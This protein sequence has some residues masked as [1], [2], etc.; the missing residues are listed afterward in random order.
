MAIQ[1]VS[2]K[3][4]KDNVLH[5][6]SPNVKRANIYKDNSKTALNNFAA[7]L[8]NFWSVAP[9]P[10]I[11]NAVLGVDASGNIIVYETP[12]QLGV[13]VTGHGHTIAQIV[14]VSD[15]EYLFSPIGSD[16]LNAWTQH[17]G[18]SGTVAVDGMAEAVEDASIT[19][20]A[21]AISYIKTSLNPSS[22]RPGYMW[23]CS[24]SIAAPYYYIVKGVALQ[25]WINAK[26]DLNNAIEAS[27][28]SDAVFPSNLD[29]TG[30]MRFAGTV[31]PAATSGAATEVGSIFPAITTNPDTKTGMYYITVADGYIKATGMNW[32][33]GDTQP[34]SIFLKK[35][36]WII[37]V[38]YEDLATDKY[39]FAYINN[40]YI[41]AATDAL[42]LVQLSAQHS[43]AT[44]VKR[45]GLASADFAANQVVTEKMLANMGLDIYQS[46]E[47][48]WVR[49]D[50][51]TGGFSVPTIPT[52]PCE[53]PES[54]TLVVV[55][56]TNPTQKYV[57]TSTGVTQ[58]VFNDLE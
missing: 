36:A 6:L 57:C 12:A 54:G 38:K 51:A 49:N 20:V 48:T 55:P 16:G 14:A 28:I 26:V 34:T 1:S 42:G 53:L 45:A 52:G 32:I 30:K 2:L 10:V 56:E 22:K 43:N 4:K 11:N 33:A 31:T 29:I 40:E 58:V 7:Q 15:S 9:T 44:T 46:T 37:F 17:T 19:S 5:Y 13:A 41:A 39:T 24:A 27:K 23:R 50:G 47:G 35:G 21:T 18:G 3:Y 25:D 8:L